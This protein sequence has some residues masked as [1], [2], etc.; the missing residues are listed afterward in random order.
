MHLHGVISVSEIT[1]ARND[2]AATMS[3]TAPRWG[4]IVYVR[5]SLLFVEALGSSD[6]YGDETMRK[7]LLT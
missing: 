1:Q 3:V 4:S 7:G 5:N 2:V 6:Q